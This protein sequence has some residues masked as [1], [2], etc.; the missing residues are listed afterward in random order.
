MNIFK[1]LIG[2]F[3]PNRDCKQEQ[4]ENVICCG[5]DKIHIAYRGLADE[6]QYIEY[7]RKYEDLRYFRKNYLKIYC[8]TCRRRI[9]LE[10]S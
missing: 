8:A 2:I 6:R 3:R 4:S 10:D 5:S 7:N 1:S 9:E